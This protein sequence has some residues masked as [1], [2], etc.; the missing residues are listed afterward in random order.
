MNTRNK[1]Q[2][3]VIRL[4]AAGLLAAA[5]A[6]MALALAGMPGLL[7]A[8]STDV[9]GIILSAVKISWSAVGFVGGAYVLYNAA[10]MVNATCLNKSRVAAIGALILP[11]LGL[12][13]IITAFALLPLGAIA[14]VLL[15]RAEWKAAFDGEPALHVS[16][17]I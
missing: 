7:A 3:E 6:H 2:K 8:S 11:F 16:M 12:N 13:G 10:S 4:V 1:R 17:E 9:F 5:A 15:R 14:V